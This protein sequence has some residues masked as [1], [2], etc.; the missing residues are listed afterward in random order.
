MVRQCVINAV[1]RIIAIIIWT[2]STSKAG[3]N[4]SYK[5]THVKKESRDSYFMTHIINK[6][7]RRESKNDS[8]LS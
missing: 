4:N 7:R 2:F 8:C 3:G 5:M 1:T 6:L